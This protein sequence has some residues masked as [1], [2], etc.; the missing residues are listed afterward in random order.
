MGPSKKGNGIQE[1]GHA[2]SWVGSGPRC[3]IRC[4][5][6]EAEVLA[7]VCPHAWCEITGARRECPGS[8]RHRKQSWSRGMGVGSKS[9]DKKARQGPSPR[10]EAV[11]SASWG[12][13]VG[14]GSRSQSNAGRRREGDCWGG[15]SEKVEGRGSRFFLASTSRQPD[16]ALRPL[17]QPGHG[18]GHSSASLQPCYHSRSR[19]QTNQMEP[20]RG[21]FLGPS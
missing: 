14:A 9:R 21:A 5:I 8:K 15:W 11:G 13:S 2:L 12:E 1:A 17:G 16:L 19:T 7:R 6:R 18:R 4:P 3:W 20:L 10:I